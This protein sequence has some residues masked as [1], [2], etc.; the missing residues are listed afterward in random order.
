MT[1][2]DLVAIA[3]GATEI[4]VGPTALTLVQKSHHGLRS[5][6]ASPRSPNSRSP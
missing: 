6:R 3:S 4:T 1:I 5:A 2:P